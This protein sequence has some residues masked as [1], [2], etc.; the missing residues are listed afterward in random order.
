LWTNKNKIEGGAKSSNPNEAGE[1]TNRENL[2][3]IRSQVEEVTEDVYLLKDI[4][5]GK[6]ILCTK[7]GKWF[8]S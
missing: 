6:W 5:E 2:Q 4:E 3:M 8:S 1:T 7:E